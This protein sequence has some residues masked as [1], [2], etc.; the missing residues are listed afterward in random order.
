MND[1]LEHAVIVHFSYGSND[2]EALFALEEKLESAIA[3]AGVGELD[4]N[5]IA[6]DGSDGNLYMYGPDADRLF[7]V[8]RPVLESAP[9]MRGAQVLKRY[10][11][12][13]DGVR[14]SIVIIGP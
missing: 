12:P 13:G 7:D 2:L 10:G 11:P 14:Q 3:S 1:T 5:E 8:I 4:G 9:F 6:A